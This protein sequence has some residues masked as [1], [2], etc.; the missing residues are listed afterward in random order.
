M[1]LSCKKCNAE[2]ISVKGYFVFSQEH[3]AFVPDPYYIDRSS[4][5]DVLNGKSK[6]HD[7]FCLQCDEYCFVKEVA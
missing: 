3:G 6:E 4:H 5:E 2:N 7:A 1:K